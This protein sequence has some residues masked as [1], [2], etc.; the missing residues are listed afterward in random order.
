MTQQQHND[1][2]V[3]TSSLYNRL[4]EFE[5]TFSTHIVVFD[6]HQQFELVMNTQV[7]VKLTRINPEDIRL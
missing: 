3:Q 4:D 6:I 7:R 5:N 1:E 2:T